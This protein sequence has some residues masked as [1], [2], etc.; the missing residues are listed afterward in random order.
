M[1]SVYINFKINY[2]IRDYNN[3]NKVNTYNTTVSPKKHETWKTTQGLLTN[4]LESMKCNSIK[5]NM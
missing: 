4:I 2:K 1:Y 5:P 3:K